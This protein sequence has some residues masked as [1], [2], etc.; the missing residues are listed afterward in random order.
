MA[1]GTTKAESEKTMGKTK[2]GTREMGEQS[3]VEVWRVETERVSVSEEELC[4]LAI[5]SSAPPILV[6]S[7]AAEALPNK[8]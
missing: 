7:R 8:P 2:R 1:R 5:F 6:R 3:G 4:A